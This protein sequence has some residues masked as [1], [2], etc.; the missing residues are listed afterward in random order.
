MAISFSGALYALFSWLN[1]TVSEDLRLESAL[2]L[3]G[4]P[5]STNWAKLTSSLFNEVFGPR[6]F[7]LRGAA[8][9]LFVTLLVAVIDFFW[10]NDFVISGKVIVARDTYFTMYYWNTWRDWLSMLLLVAV[11]PLPILFLMIPKTRWLLELLAKRPTAFL[12]PVLLAEILI[13]VSATKV[14]Q[15]ILL[16]PFYHCPTHSTAGYCRALEPFN[17]FLANHFFVDLFYEP[18]FI[19]YYLSTICVLL[20]IAAVL[21]RLSYI[22]LSKVFGRI[23]PYLNRERVEKEPIKLFGETL[24]GLVFLVIV[25]IG[26]VGRSP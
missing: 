21:L 8:S 9:L 11:F 16:I 10:R 26:V 23:S 25:F 12:F 24:A 1:K 22:A 2:W 19:L 18:L 15:E 5:S 14:W 20:V 13:T 17:E 6:T 7:R 4:E 3:M